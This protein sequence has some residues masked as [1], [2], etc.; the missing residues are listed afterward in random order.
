MD[1]L[2]ALHLNT[3][4]SHKLAHTLHALLADGHLHVGVLGG[5]HGGLV[6]EE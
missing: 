5:N 3:F 6:A 4:L 2:L 1:L